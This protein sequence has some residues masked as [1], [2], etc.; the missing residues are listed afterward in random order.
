MKPSSGRSVA[1]AKAAGSL[2][3]RLVDDLAARYEATGAFGKAYEPQ[4]NAFETSRTLASYRALRDERQS[5]KWESVRERALQ[6]LRSDAAASA[7]HRHAGLGSGRGPRVDQRA[8]ER[9]Q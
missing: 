8:N 5:R 3:A 1:C 6:Q 7:A 2:D 9:Q 4:Q